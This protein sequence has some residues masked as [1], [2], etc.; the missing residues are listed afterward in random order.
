MTDVSIVILTYKEAPEVLAACLAAVASSRSLRDR[1]G[2]LETCDYELIVVDNAG[3]LATK[4]LV[5]ELLPDAEYIANNI[6]RGFAAAV[7]QGMRLATGRYVLL[8]NPDTVVPPDAIEQMV[9]HMDA[10]TEVGI[11][12]CIIRYP[13]GELQDSIRRFPRMI[14]QLLIML[15]V[16]HFIRRVW[17]IDDYMMRDV[18]AFKT[19]DVDSIMGAF[20]MIR[21]SV[22][23][24][25]GLFDERYFIW[26]EEVDYCK[27]AYDAG[28]K[29]RHYA[30]V[31]IVH[32]KGHTFDQLATIRKQKWVRES[33]RK[34]FAKHHGVGPAMILWILAPLFIVLA[35]GA[36]V[37]KRG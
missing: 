15:K 26:F 19:Q 3:S 1:A 8:L 20:M 23:E 12:S 24:K 34:Y 6:N 18:D 22:I 17:S 25:I 10:D 2:H 36:A 37:I 13:N 16:P 21:R 14:D 31:E 33:M 11:G 9:K 30:D 28:F 27:M 7:N 32:H 5:N 4:E 35:Y 29:I